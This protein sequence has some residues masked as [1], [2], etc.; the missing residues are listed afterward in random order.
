MR[1][2]VSFAAS[3]LRPGAPY[4]RSLA[5]GRPCPTLGGHPGPG[6]QLS[7]SVHACRILVQSIHPA[8]GIANSQLQAGQARHQVGPMF[9][10]D[11]SGNVSVESF[12]RRVNLEHSLFGRFGLGFHRVKYQKGSWHLKAKRCSRHLK[13]K[14]CPRNKEPEL[15]ESID[16]S[17]GWFDLGFYRV[18]FVF[19]SRHLILVFRPAKHLIKWGRCS[20]AIHLATFR[21]SLSRGG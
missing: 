1:R 10:R 4:G 18:S 21:L 5:Y 6:P 3:S 8:N 11:S 14:R 19:G 13:A 16:S 2:F 9:R 7:G 12:S 20:A 15:A 17:F